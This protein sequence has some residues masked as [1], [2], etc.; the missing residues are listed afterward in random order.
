[1]QPVLVSFRPGKLHVLYW[2]AL[3]QM[4]YSTDGVLYR[5]FDANVVLFTSWS[6]Q[7]AQFFPRVSKSIELRQSYC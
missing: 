7:T 4:V 3:K 2:Q 6:L 1:M 5:W